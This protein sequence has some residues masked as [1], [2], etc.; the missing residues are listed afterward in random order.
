MASN[1]TPE[2]VAAMRQVI[3]EVN[4]STLQS[5]RLLVRAFAQAVQP[6]VRAV[7]AF[8]ESIP[9]EVWEHARAE[10]RRR[11]RLTKEDQDRRLT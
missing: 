2:E 3:A 6:S 9:P 11:L 4:R 7:Q 10:E 5:A 8:A 1:L